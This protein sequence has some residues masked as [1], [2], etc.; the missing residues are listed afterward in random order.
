MARVKPRESNLQRLHRALVVALGQEPVARFMAPGV[1]V[2]SAPNLPAAS[3]GSRMATRERVKKQ[4][5]A[6]FFVGRALLRGASELEPGVPWGVGPWVVLFVRVAP[7]RLDDD[8][9]AGA[10]KAI[11]DGVA[12][13]FGYNDG[14]EGISW[15]YDQAR[16]GADRQ[17]GIEVTLWRAP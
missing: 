13:A 16:P 1:E 5:Q 8:N 11:R 7:K 10:F 2:V 15:L 9:L 17:P 3:W 14:S 4:R 6:G 12:D